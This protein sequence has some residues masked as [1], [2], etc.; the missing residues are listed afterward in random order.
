M[1]MGLQQL[2][3]AQKHGGMAVVATGVHTAIVRAVVHISL[4]TD[5]KGIHIST[6]QEAFS[7][8]S[9]GGY[10]AAF[11]HTARIVAHFP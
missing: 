5:G 10:Q 2:G 1:F 8:F 3:R 7:R 6:E 4:L 11:S 9:H